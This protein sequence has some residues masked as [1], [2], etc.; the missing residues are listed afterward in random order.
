MRVTVNDLFS[1]LGTLRNTLLILLSQGKYKG[2]GNIFEGQ[3]T[4]RTHSTKSE[5]LGVVSYGEVFFNSI[6]PWIKKMKIQK[7]INYFV[8]KRN[9]KLLYNIYKKKQRKWRLFSAEKFWKK[10]NLRGID[11]S[12]SQEL[13][14]YPNFLW[15]N[16]RYV[17]TYEKMC[18]VH[19]WLYI[20]KSLYHYVYRNLYTVFYVEIYVEG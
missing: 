11:I 12:K 2:L 8:E 1:L 6:S 13:W 17:K 5:D 7:K 9:V 19:M 10:F 3:K 15:Q 18:T 20:R 14:E 4:W 16:F